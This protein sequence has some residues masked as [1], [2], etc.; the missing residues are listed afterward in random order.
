MLARPLQVEQAGAQ[1]PHRLGAVFVLRLLI[2]LS[3]HQAGRQMGDA[4]RAVGGVDRLAAGP[5]GAID[6]D[7]Q[8][9][10]STA[11]S[12]SAASGSTA[13]VAAEV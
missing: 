9:R 7:T 11:M 2:L 3:D 13:T 12:I 6:I 1:D 8:S 10:S 5:A 4:H